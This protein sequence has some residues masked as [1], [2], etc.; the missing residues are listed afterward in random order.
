[1]EDHQIQDNYYVAYLE[2]NDEW[3]N[4]VNKEFSSECRF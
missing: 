1:M 4:S 2:Y 3:H